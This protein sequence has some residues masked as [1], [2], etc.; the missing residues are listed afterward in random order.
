MRL[1]SLLVYDHPST[2]C[3]KQNNAVHLL[4][5]KFLYT[6]QNLH[7]QGA[8]ANMNEEMSPE[9]LVEKQRIVIEELK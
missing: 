6:V 9:K 2:T 3:N 7:L 8:S 4:N 5:F 1:K